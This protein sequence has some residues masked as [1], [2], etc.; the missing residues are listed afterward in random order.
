MKEFRDRVA[1][2]FNRR[3]DA[4]ATIVGGANLHNAITRWL[5]GRGKDN[6]PR[7]QVATTERL[8]DLLT[9]NEQDRQTHLIWPLH[10]SEKEYARLITLVEGTKP[11][12]INGGDPDSIVGG[13]RAY[14]AAIEDK[15]A[16][17]K[18]AASFQD[19]ALNI[20]VAGHVPGIHELTIADFD[21]PRDD[22]FFAD[23]RKYLRGALPSPST[24]VQA[25]VWRKDSS[26][27]VDLAEAAEA[28]ILH[29]P[30]GEG[31]STVLLQAAHEAL[32][33]GYRVFRVANRDALE[34]LT[35]VVAWT[36][37]PIVIMDDA[38][39]PQ[40]GIQSPP[41]WMAASF[42]DAPHGCLILGTRTRTRALVQQALS[43]RGRRD[44]ALQAVPVQDSRPY[45]DLIMAY[46]ACLEGSDKSRVEELFN[47]GL[48][49]LQARAGLWPAMYQATRG[50]LLR[51]RVRTLAS[52]LQ[53][54]VRRAL[55]ALVFVNALADR[56]NKPMPE[57]KRKLL[58]ALV[59]HL[60]LH[61]EATDEVKRALR[62]LPYDLEGELANLR[63]ADE[64]SQAD[65]PTLEIRHPALTDI[66]FHYLLDE[67]E[68]WKVQFSKW[69]Y[70]EALIRAAA[71]NGLEHGI[72]WEVLRAM[73][74]TFNAE[75]TLAH[76]C[77]H[78]LSEAAPR[79]GDV[80]IQAIEAAI[81]AFH[82]FFSD[83]GH[84]SRLINLMHA[85]ILTKPERHPTLEDNATATTR[86]DAALANASKERDF[87]ALSAAASLAQKIGY[88]GHLTIGG[89]TK[90]AD[91][92]VIIELAEG[93]EKERSKRDKGGN[94]LQSTRVY[95]ECALRDHD[96]TPPNELTALAERARLLE[97]DLLWGDHRLMTLK[98][99]LDACRNP[100][101]QS[102]G[103]PLPL[104]EPTIGL[105]SVRSIYRA[106]WRELHRLQPSA[107][108]K[109][110]KAFTSPDEKTFLRDLL[111]A[112]LEDWV[113]DDA[114]HPEVWPAG[115]MAA[116]IEA[117]G[118]R[119]KWLQFAA[120]YSQFFD[121]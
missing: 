120:A 19:L 118:D 76:A 59:E 114:E 75:A 57:A 4:L 116:V 110:N 102:I 13:L 26:D 5:K 21:R 79:V 43:G 15:P 63:S 32:T 34:N 87:I 54:A 84:R 39:D 23:A 89:V 104:G 103:A 27:I 70:Y 99:I 82:P 88:V 68:E 86:L 46:G 72:A 113:R 93:F 48:Q 51:D 97:D 96:L 112:V 61:D 12:E 83:G 40:T 117:H 74:R 30:T 47:N 78:M 105:R 71:S 33:R 18:K 69:P 81:S 14:L 29:G 91:W 31:T 58:E 90:A 8:I 119:S 60:P 52:S 55:S 44:Q 17:T 94:S 109:R 98:R 111:V 2:N 107:T 3:N 80:A 92:K 24:A 9:R 73:E 45:V 41:S 28:I 121:Q 1:K 62:R 53:P 106:F 6:N 64:L 77:R 56:H 20:R 108:F 42:G 37:G 49:L 16:T 66:F 7:F 25:A 10:G 95:L 11:S 85:R 115:A 35:Q 22:A 100:R 38:A 65:N 36:T 67:D 101:W 50:E